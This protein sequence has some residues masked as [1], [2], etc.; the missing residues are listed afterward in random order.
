MDEI[1]RTFAAFIAAI[2]DGGLHADLTGQLKALVGE[3]CAEAADGSGN[4]AGALELKLNLALRD[5]VFEVRGEST[6]RRPKRKRARS[7]FW[8]TPENFLTR[9]NPRQQDLFPR[10]VS[11]HSEGDIHVG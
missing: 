3:I 1:L 7:V 11:H 9:L 8:A 2:E 4:A 10:A 6:V 5:G